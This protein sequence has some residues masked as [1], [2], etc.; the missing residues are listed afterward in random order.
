MD[1]CLKAR[2]W[3]NVKERSESLIIRETE[4][5]PTLENH[6]T[7][8][9]GSYSTKRVESLQ[10]AAGSPLVRLPWQTARRA[11]RTRET[12]LLHDPVSPLPGAGLTPAGVSA[13]CSSTRVHNSAVHQRPRGKQP[14]SPAGPRADRLGGKRSS[15]TEDDDAR[16]GATADGPWGRRS[17]RPAWPHSGQ[18]LL[19]DSRDRPGSTGIEA[20]ADGGAGWGLQGRDLTGKASRFRE[21][22]RFWRRCRSW[23]HVV[24]RALMLGD[25]TR[26][27]LKGLWRSRGRVSTC[28]FRRC[29][30]NISLEFEPRGFRVREEQLP[31]RGPRS[32]RT[33]SLCGAGLRTQPG[34]PLLRTRGK[35]SPQPEDPAHG[36]TEG[37]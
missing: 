11:L 32:T 28:Q 2:E 14:A 13:R 29:G 21:T 19:C 9:E 4:I 10:T 20:G 15:A 6:L 16:G 1:V 22:G 31:P 5:K 23:L 37:E 3:P 27:R 24:K 25:C 33:R 18:A 8:C 26:L 12:H 17:V 35:S 30:F 7:S 34:R 36:Q